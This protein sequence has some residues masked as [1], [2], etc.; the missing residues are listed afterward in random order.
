MGSG[1]L[2]QLQA[3][4]TV[5]IADTADFESWWHFDIPYAILY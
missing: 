4:G 3:A 1:N 5:L 2:E